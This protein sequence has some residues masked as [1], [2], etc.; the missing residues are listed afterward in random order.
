MASPGN[1][2]CSNCIGTLSLYAAPS[3]L[4]IETFS[5]IFA[6]YNMYRRQKIN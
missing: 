4:C 1:Q 6:K 2:H 3:P 5:D